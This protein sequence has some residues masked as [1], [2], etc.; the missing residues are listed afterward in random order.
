MLN[1]ME[2]IIVSVPTPDAE[3]VTKLLEKMGYCIRNRRL[4]SNNAPSFREVFEKVQRES[5][6][7]HEWTLE[8]INA[9]INAARQGK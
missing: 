8:E 5:S 9:E 7:N 2:D 3:F 6:D 1:T 4:K